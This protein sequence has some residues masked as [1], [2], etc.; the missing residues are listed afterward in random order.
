MAEKLSDFLIELS[1][2]PA[3]VQAFVA[4]PDT[5]LD[6][7]GLAEHD[8]KIIKS[9][10]IDAIQETIQADETIPPI[11]KSSAASIILPEPSRPPKPPP[12]RLA[13]AI[14][15]PNPLPRPPD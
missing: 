9:G 13:V 2:D 3:E 5:F 8:K 15:R 14:V 12:S 6:R 10:D 1:N 11:I 7:S 4:D